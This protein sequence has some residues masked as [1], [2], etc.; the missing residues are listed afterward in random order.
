VLTQRLVGHYEVHFPLGDLLKLVLSNMVEP[1]Q[2]GDVAEWS[3]RHTSCVFL[4]LPWS[5][6]GLENTFETTEEPDY[7]VNLEKD[8]DVGVIQSKD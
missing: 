1:L 3:R 6:L 7:M 5:F 4:P 8:D 2:V